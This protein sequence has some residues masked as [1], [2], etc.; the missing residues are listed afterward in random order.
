MINIKIMNFSAII[1]P[2]IKIFTIILWLVAVALV[3]YLILFPFYPGIMYRV[4][5]SSDS[6]TVDYKSEEQAADQ[7]EQVFGS[8]PGNEFSSIN[9]LYIPKIGV[10]APIIE[11]SNE[12]Y[13]LDK[14][15]WRMPDTSTPDKGGNTVITGHRFKYFPPNNL[16]F[17]NLDKLEAGDIIT[18]V[19]NEQLEYYKVKEIKVVPAEDLS[20]LNQTQDPV[21]TLLTCTPLFSTANRLVVVADKLESPEVQ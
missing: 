20:V 18:V 2:L 11:S 6:Q 7:A 16:T 9:R 21:L 10:N 3:S 4:G 8:L 15:A 14:G 19:W 1:K 13:G 5:E 12:A 17:Y